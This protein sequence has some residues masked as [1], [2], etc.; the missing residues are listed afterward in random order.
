MLRSILTAG[1]FAFAVAG[2]GV[3]AQTDKADFDALLKEHW[4]QANEE[5]IFF[6]TDPD[7]YR[8]NGKLAEFSKEAR[9]RRAA[10][11]ADML[12]RL[13]EIDESRLSGQER[14]SYKLFST[15]R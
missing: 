8:P 7:A 3:S 4:A 15:L 13:A 12:K 10:F 11:N 9:A 5:Q 14:I 1:F 2:S 6:R